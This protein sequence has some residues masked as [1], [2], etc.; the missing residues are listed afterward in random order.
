MSNMI[1][2]MSDFCYF[3]RVS[4]PRF[5]NDFI[6]Y[7]KYKISF[8]LHVGKMKREEENLVITFI[9]R[10]GKPVVSS[11]K[12]NDRYVSSLH[13]GVINFLGM[14]ENVAGRIGY[15]DLSSVKDVIAICNIL[16]KGLEINMN[17]NFVEI[18]SA[19]GDTVRVRRSGFY[20]DNSSCWIYP[21]VPWRITN[22]TNLIGF[23]MNCF[24]KGSVVRMSSNEILLP[25]DIDSI[26]NIINGFEKRANFYW[27]RDNFDHWKLISCIGQELF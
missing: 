27:D 4:S 21:G 12:N 16:K 17:R 19:E 25:T 5:L 24:V 13:K 2:S 3:F 26:N 20:D 22:Q 7:D 18:I 10:D 11:V 15:N 6:N 1:D 8:D 23:R 9:M 14:D